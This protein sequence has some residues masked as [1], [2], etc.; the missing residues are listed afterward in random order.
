MLKRLVM[1]TA[2][3][4]AFG[5]VV[6]GCEISINDDSIKGSGKIIN[7]SRQATSFDAIHNSSPFNV[8]LIVD[9]KIALKSKA[10][11]I[12]FAKLKPR[13]KMVL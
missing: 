5:V 2:I 12:L 8:L 4:M 6:S 1:S 10:T 9:G 11:T 13:S 7:E 3:V